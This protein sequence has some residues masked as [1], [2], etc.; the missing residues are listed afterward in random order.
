MGRKVEHEI[1]VTIDGNGQCK[2][3]IEVHH[4]SLKHNAEKTGLSVHWTCNVDGVHIDELLQKA[5]RQISV[6][7][8]GIREFPYDELVEKRAQL[9]G[10]TVDF[11]DIKT[12]TTR[13]SKGRRKLED[14]P[15][16][17]L[18]NKLT[19]EQIAEIIKRANG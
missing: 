18:M 10:A 5:A 4:G 2:G 9:N 15:V 7:M 6:D 1:D 8:A 13:G 16:D 3:T 14:M 12:W 11:K 19:K 17:E